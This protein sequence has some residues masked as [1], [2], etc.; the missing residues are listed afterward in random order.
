MLI[1]GGGGNAVHVLGQRAY[2]ASLNFPLNFSV[3]RKLP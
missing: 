1:T 2:E 3:K